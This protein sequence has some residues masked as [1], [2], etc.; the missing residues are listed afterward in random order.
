MDDLRLAVAIHRT[1]A[2]ITVEGNLDF[3][4]T[5]AL[6]AAIDRCAH[7]RAHRVEIRFG[8]IALMDSSGLGALVYAHKLLH[9]RGKD[10]ELIG[11]DAIV[12]HLL[13][14][15]SLDR[16]FRLHPL[17]PANHDPQAASA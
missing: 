13:K 8:H 7:S 3:S 4:T 2:V 12:K 15:T 14:R 1:V 5:A 10:L 11:D 16:V 9:Q 17:H 6:R